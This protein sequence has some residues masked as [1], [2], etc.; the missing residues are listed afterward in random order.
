MGILV[1][2]LT[3]RGVEVLAANDLPLETGVTRLAEPEL[4]RHADLMVAIGGDGTMLYAGRLASDS[5]VPLLGIN[6]GR[7]G[8][9]ADV[10]PDEMLASVEK[11][12][13]GEYTRDSRLQLRATLKRA[14]GSTVFGDA[15]NDVVLQR[16]ETGPEPRPIPPRCRASR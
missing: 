4:P 14:D 3:E 16:V 15:L 11:V 8:F 12:L 1:R 2:Y 13:N 5:G 9:L 7:L 10:R 6:R